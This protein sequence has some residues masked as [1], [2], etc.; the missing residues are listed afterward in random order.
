MKVKSFK[1][2]LE[3]RLNKAE[4][5]EIEKAAKIEYEILHTLQQD[6]AKDV[7]RFMSENHL[8]F[9]DLVRKL[10]KNPTQVSNIIKGDAN[11]TMATI[12]QLYALMGKK[13][14]IRK[15]AT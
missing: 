12:A 15:E 10:G 9:N 5:A 6:V 4:I 8:G 3:K 2:Y 13:A 7:V 1:A 14:R 11:L